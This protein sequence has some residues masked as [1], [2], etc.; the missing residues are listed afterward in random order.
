MSK[1]TATSI[2]IFSVAKM[3]GQ[4]ESYADAMLKKHGVTSLPRY[5]LP[6]DGLDSF[7]SDMTAFNNTEPSLTKQE[8]TESCDPNFILDRHARGQDISLTGIPS[9]GDFTNVPRS[10]HEAL[11]IVTRANQSFM[12]L[13]AKLRAKFEN[14]PAQF[15]DFVSNPDNLPEMIKLGLASSRDDSAS[16]MPPRSTDSAVGGK[17]DVLPQG[18]TEGGSS[19]S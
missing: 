13:D 8:F 4:T 19:A 5:R 6:D 3:F 9:Y 10:Y 18:K 11:N 2:D 14:D 15:L 12:Q 1:S 17:D 7:Y 16:S